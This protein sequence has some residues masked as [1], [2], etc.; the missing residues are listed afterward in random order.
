MTS[1]WHF[2]KTGPDGAPVL[3]D[4]TPARPGIV[5]VKG[6]IVL[7]AQGLHASARVIDALDYAPGPWLSRVTLRG[8]IIH[9]EDK[10]VAIE[11]E[12]EGYKDMLPVLQEFAV[13]CAV[14]ALEHERDTGRAPDERSWTVCDLA[15]GWLAGVVDMETLRTAT[16][17]AATAVYTASAAVYAAYATA[18]AATRAAHAAAYAVDAAHATDAARVAASVAAYV[19]ARAAVYVIERAAQN[20]E[21]EEMV[22]AAYETKR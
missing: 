8:E 13:R 21:L 20:D 14:R 9:G 4:G 15:L 6:P 7:C 19:A 5:R 16:A 11:R 18:D 22:F 17:D 12:A 10:M 2:A 1:G 3:R